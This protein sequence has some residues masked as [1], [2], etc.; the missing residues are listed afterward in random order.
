MKRPTDKELM[1]AIL[2]RLSL[3]AGTSGTV[4]ADLIAYAQLRALERLADNVFNLEQTLAVIRADMAGEGSPFSATK[5]AEV[6]RGV[7]KAGGASPSSKGL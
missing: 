4:N 2:D 3:S 1:D 6:F 5:M 7:K